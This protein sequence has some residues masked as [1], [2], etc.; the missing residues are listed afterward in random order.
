[1]KRRGF[2]ERLGAS[3]LLA[4]TSPGW[5]A[6]LLPH[7]SPESDP[8]ALGAVHDSEFFYK[9]QGAWAADF[10]PFYDQGRFHLFYLHDWRDVPG[11]G[12]GTP[13]YQVST[14]D[15]VHFT[16]HGQMLARGTKDEQDLYVFTG[17]AIKAEGRYHIFY[18]GHNP[19]FAKQGKPQEAIMHA[20][21]D[22]L[23][24]WIK[25]PGRHVLCS[26]GTL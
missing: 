22:D 2:I 7:A 5:G 1:M 26:P 19:Y 12:E 10:I 13:W 25:V 24:S 9:P 17:S 18:V 11:H 15:F 21:S 8:M 6:N 23:L 20:V 4:G 3:A 16:E 14:T